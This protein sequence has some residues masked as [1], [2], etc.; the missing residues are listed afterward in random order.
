MTACFS[1]PCLFLRQCRLSVFSVKLQDVLVLNLLMLFFQDSSHYL[2]LLPTFFLSFV[3]IFLSAFLPFCPYHIIPL[4]PFLS[5]CLHSLSLP[6]PFPCHPPIAFLISL[7]DL[8]SSLLTSS[9][10]FHCLSFLDS[11]SFSFSCISHSFSLIA[12]SPYL[13]LILMSQIFQD[14]LVC[15]SF[16]LTNYP[17]LL[18]FLFSSFTFPS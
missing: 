17:L 3:S 11:Y 7:V 6:L 18:I 8:F 5:F 4:I 1:I 9:I 14:F 12:I 10:I 16:P 2:P 15:N 13:L